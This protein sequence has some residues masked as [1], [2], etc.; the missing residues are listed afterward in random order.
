[1]KTTVAI[2]LAAGFAMNAGAETS[3]VIRIGVMNDM[4][5]PYSDNAGKGSVVA[6]RMAA[7]E[8]RRPTLA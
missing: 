3:S 1:M 7:D 5:G 4:S 8:S 6:A 2:L